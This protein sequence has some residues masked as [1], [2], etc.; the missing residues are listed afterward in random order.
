MKPQRTIYHYWKLSLKNK[1]GFINRH[2]KDAVKSCELQHT[3][4]FTT[5]KEV[6]WII[7]SKQIHDCKIDIEDM[8][9][10]EMIWRK[11]TPYLR[12]NNIY[13]NSIWLS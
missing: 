13:K 5:V 3:L 12:G 9:N 8:E 7:W 2:V 4:I 11:D 10:A 6:K 1:E